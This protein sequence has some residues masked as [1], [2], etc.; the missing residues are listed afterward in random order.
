M[1]RFS[2]L[3]VLALAVGSAGAAFCSG[4]PDAG[5]RVNDYPIFDAAETLSF[6]SSV[7]NAQIWEVSVLLC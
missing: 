3:V 7:E 4:T 2:S 6:V 5:E 1:G